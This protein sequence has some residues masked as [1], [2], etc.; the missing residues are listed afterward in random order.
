MANRNLKESEA[1]MA[2]PLAQMSLSA[3]LSRLAGD[4]PVIPGAGS[5]ACV[6][7]T[8]AAALGRMVAALSARGDA[9]GGGGK[10]LADIGARLEQ[11]QH[12]CSSLMAEEA[13]ECAG[14]LAA[15]ALPSNTADEKAHRRKALAEARI[16]ALGP[17]AALAEMAA[18]ILHTLQGVR[19]GLPSP[20]VPDLQVAAE[21][22]AAGLNS[23]L[24]LARAN[25]AGVVDPD[26]QRHF[27][28]IL[29]IAEAEG[30][31]AYRSIG[32]AEPR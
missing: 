5:A 11:L 13:T 22:A 16:A 14:L 28:S 7:G 31:T 24:I 1:G 12:R 23:A 9:A 20:I 10:R 2:Q 17:P 8:M 30:R 4:R 21:L 25:L 19:P 6:I 29:N 32:Q 27:A 18:E 15:L 26:I 3:F